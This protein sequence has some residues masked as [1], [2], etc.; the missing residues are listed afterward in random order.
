LPCFNVFYRSHLITHFLLLKRFFNQCTV[1]GW[2][3]GVTLSLQ[4]VWFIYIIN[5][6]ERV[7]HISALKK[8]IVSCAGFCHIL[9]AI[10]WRNKLRAKRRRNWDNLEIPLN[11]LLLS[12]IV[13]IQTI[14]TV[15]P[16][17]LKYDGKL[18]FEI[19]L[20]IIIYHNAICNY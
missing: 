5:Q 16:A 15:S 10:C 1:E 11:P 8:T 17:S 13:F 20:L 14:Q 7:V 19:D 4:N 2:G 12:S 3:R 6:I 9:I 18:C